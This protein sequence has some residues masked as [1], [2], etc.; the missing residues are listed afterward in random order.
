VTPLSYCRHLLSI[1]L[2]VQQEVEGWVRGGT[3][4]ALRRAVAGP[5]QCSCSDFGWHF[6]ALA[7]LG[8]GSWG[9]AYVVFLSVG[10]KG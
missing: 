4:F 5:F 9:I 1:T 8:V 7:C 10:L 2:L 6:T 3:Y